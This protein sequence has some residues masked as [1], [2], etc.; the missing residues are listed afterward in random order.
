M[1]LSRAPVALALAAAALGLAGC[2]GSGDPTFQG[3]VEAELV[4]VGPDEVGRVQTLAVKE[5][6][7]IETGKPLF[8]VDND[9]QV[10]DLQASVAAVAQ[11]K[12]QLARQE[13][14]QQ[15][16]EQIAVLQ[17]Q[18]RR[19][20]SALA[21]STIELER[22]RTLVTKGIASKA[23]FD[24]AQANYDRDKASLEEMRRQIDVARTASRDE[25]IAAARESLAAAQARQV[26]SQT[27][28]DRRKVASPVSG[29]VQQVYYR[30]GEM[31][32]AGKP[33]VALLP[34]GNLK[35]RFFVPESELPKLAIG[36]TVQIR[37]DGCAADLTARI[38]FLA[39]T[40]EYTPPVIYSQD[41]RAKLVFLVEARPAKPEAFRVGQPVSV[42]IPQQHEAKR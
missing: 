41:E 12:A 2:N 16:K 8:T 13:N 22:Q 21:L 30:P 39:R 5:G 40:A 23:A 3:W 4:F 28:L 37:C 24:T 19:A 10:S 14:A 25:D 38:D 7:E 6:S 35:F 11:A 42:V 1:R 32:P 27:R 26:A 31:V 36:E 20:E 29:T 34:P 17:A 18:E 15:T 33:V 9:L